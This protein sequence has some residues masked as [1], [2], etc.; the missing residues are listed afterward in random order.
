MYITAEWMDGCENSIEIIIITLKECIS[1]TNF[2]F[3][4]KHTTAKKI[5][6]TIDECKICGQNKYSI[7]QTIDDCHSFF[8]KN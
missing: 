8:D 1:K 5:T 3:G 2:F 4:N 6:Q 7:L